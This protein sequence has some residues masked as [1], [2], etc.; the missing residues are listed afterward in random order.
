VKEGYLHALLVENGACRKIVLELSCI[1]E[2]VAQ[3]WEIVA[4]MG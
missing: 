1:V 2:P 3:S 4:K